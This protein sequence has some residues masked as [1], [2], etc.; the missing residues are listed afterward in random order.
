MRARAGG[1]ARWLIL[2][3]VACPA[4]QAAALDLAF[5]GTAELVRTTPPAPGRLPLATGPWAEGGVPTTEAEGIVEDRV[6]WITAPDPATFPLVAALR[7]QMEA[8][9]YEI[10]FACS[11][12]ECGGFDFRHA[13]PL[14]AP[15]DMHVDLGDFHYVAARIDGADGP[16][17]AAL[18]V[19]RGGMTGFVHLALVAPPAPA[20]LPVVSSTLSPATA[21][22]PPSGP[23]EVGG[24]VE[25]DM[26]AR[27][28]GEGAVALE[29]LRFE[30]G[31]SQ[32]SGAEFPSLAALAEFLL[33]NP[34]RRVVLVGHTDATGALPGNI[35][36]SEAR[37]EAVRA[38]LTEV[39]GVNAAQVAAEGIGYLAPRA[40]NGT[41]A[42]R[43]ANRRVEVV[44]ADPG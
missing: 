34:A 36:L 24:A 16:S 15:P 14:G 25:G 23:A 4:P 1:R 40:T 6:W 27:L 38:Y 20:A 30:T 29:D 32:L 17:F 41:E 37:A 33:E 22:P 21:P 42:G 43:E 9:G 13:M 8:Q 3:L 35:A 12:T 19:S 44:L 10:L 31:A 26:I 2:M 28:L 5:P 39:L 11:A 7:A 18:T